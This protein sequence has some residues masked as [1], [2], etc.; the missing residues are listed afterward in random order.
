M[1][2][3]GAGMGEPLQKFGERVVLGIAN[4]GTLVRAQFV[5]FGWKLMGIERRMSSEGGHLEDLTTVTRTT[6]NEC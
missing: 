5:E 4:V 1:R 2:G 3:I 6:L